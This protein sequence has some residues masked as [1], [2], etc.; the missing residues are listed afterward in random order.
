MQTPPNMG[1]FRKR[2]LGRGFRYKLT[3]DTV[4][5]GAHDFPASFE[6]I[7]RVLPRTKTDRNRE[8]GFTQ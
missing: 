2:A 4:V 3:A 6:N 1:L 8:W 5:G 7:L